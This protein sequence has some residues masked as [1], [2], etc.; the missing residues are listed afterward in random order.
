MLGHQIT[1]LVYPVSLHLADRLLYRSLSGIH[2]QRRP[3]LCLA[4]SFTP[5]L[6]HVCDCTAAEP[7]A[8]SLSTDPPPPSCPHPSLPGTNLAAT[9]DVISLQ[10]H[11]KTMTT[12]W[13]WQLWKPLT[14][15][16]ATSS[17]RRLSRS[18][19]IRASVASMRSFSTIRPLIRKST[20]RSTTRTVERSVERSTTRTAEDGV[21]G[22][23]GRVQQA[24]CETTPGLHG[25]LVMM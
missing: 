11:V 22:V 13:T 25:S 19:A 14:R 10:S 4:A 8:L 24:V 2:L 17:F 23:L 1:T 16:K 9:L 18:M 15:S 21:W 12:F 20:C 3:S 7:Q 6:P 5:F